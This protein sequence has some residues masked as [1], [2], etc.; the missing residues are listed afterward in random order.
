MGQKKI[1]QLTPLPFADINS[2]GNETIEISGF[3]NSTNNKASFSTTLKELG[4]AIFSKFTFDDNKTI[5]QKIDEAEVKNEFTQIYLLDDLGQKWM[6]WADSESGVNWESEE[7]GI[8]RQEMG[9]YMV[10]MNTPSSQDL[11]HNYMALYDEAVRQKYN[12]NKRN[13]LKSYG[14]DLVEIYSLNPQ[15]QLA[16]KSEWDEKQPTFDHVYREIRNKLDPPASYPYPSEKYYFD[17]EFASQN[18]SIENF[19]TRLSDTIS[20]VNGHSIILIPD[21]E[22]REQDI[23]ITNDFLYYLQNFATGILNIAVGARTEYKNYYT[24]EKYQYLVDKVKEARVILG[25]DKDIDLL[26][27]FLAGVINDVD[28]MS[29]YKGYNEYIVYCN[30]T[31]QATDSKFQP[32]LDALILQLKQLANQLVV[33]IQEYFRQIRLGNG[34]TSTVN[35]LRKNIMSNI[36][37]S[38][39]TY[40]EATDLEN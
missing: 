11:K 37:K 4:Q 13:R 1:S 29:D 19:N 25:Q 38:K 23:D 22:H 8:W 35:D 21:P 24:Q 39:N 34:S 26:F 12:E 17:P 2:N 10:F 7:T 31:H 30:S 5:K 14:D 32:K 36:T 18:K 6:I 15:E 9:E 3:D 33:D 27:S 20:Y 40:V 28:N 16:R